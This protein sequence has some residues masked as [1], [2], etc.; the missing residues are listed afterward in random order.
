VAAWPTPLIAPSPAVQ[1]P[2]DL[3]KAVTGSQPARR[4]TF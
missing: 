1:Q 2:R 4:L 3:P